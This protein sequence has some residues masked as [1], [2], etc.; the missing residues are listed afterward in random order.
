MSFTLSYQVISQQP[1]EIATN[2]IISFYRCESRST[3]RLSDRSR[4]TQ[5]LRDKAGFWS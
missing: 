4:V 1:C 3:E 2:A 5:L